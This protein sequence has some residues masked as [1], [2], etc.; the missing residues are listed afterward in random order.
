MKFQNDIA[1]EIIS[2]LKEINNKIDEV[3]KRGRDG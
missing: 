2:K 3:I 1:E